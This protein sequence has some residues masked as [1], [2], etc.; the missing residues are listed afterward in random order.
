[1]LASRRR[2][3]LRAGFDRIKQS[4]WDEVVKARSRSVVAREQII[5]DLQGTELELRQEVVKLQ[6]GF[7]RFK[8][9]VLLQRMTKRRMARIV[10]RWRQAVHLSLIHI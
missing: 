5:N 2:K 4:H 10:R 7:R 9:A 6:S 1:M 8:L 3:S